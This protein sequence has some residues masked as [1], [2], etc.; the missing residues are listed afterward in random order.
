MTVMQIRRT[1]TPGNQPAPNS[2]AEGEL[3]VDM[4]EPGGP[5]LWV[6][7]PPAIDP[8]GLRVVVDPSIGYVPLDGSLPMTGPLSQTDG[9]E[10]WTLGLD[11]LAP[12][13]FTIGTGLGGLGERLRITP[14]PG[15]PLIVGDYGS[16]TIGGSRLFFNSVTVAGEGPEI[17]A[18]MNSMEIRG[19]TAEPDYI[20]RWIHAGIMTMELRSQGGTMLAITGSVDNDATIRLLTYGA[21]GNNWD[22]IAQSP[23][24]SLPSGFTIAD[25]TDRR[26]NIHAGV[27]PPVEILATGELILALDPTDPMGAV[28]KQYADA[29]TAGTGVYVPV[30][31]SVPMTGGLEVI[32]VAGGLQSGIIIDTRA[33]PGWSA[34]LALNSGGGHWFVSS[35][36]TNYVTPGAL[37]I[38]DIAS[39]NWSRFEIH[40]QTGAL[41]VLPVIIDGDGDLTVDRAFKFGNRPGVFPLQSMGPSI[42]S[43][44]IAMRFESA[45]QFVFYGSANVGNAIL[46]ILSRAPVGGSVG[47]VGV[48]G[49]LAAFSVQVLGDSQAPDADATISL[50][51][52]GNQS[53]WDLIAQSPTSS[54]LP[55][56]FTIADAVTG[57]RRFNIHAGATGAP[58]ELLAT[59]ELLLALDP[60]DPMGAVTKQYADALTSAGGLVNWSVTEAG[61]AP[62]AYTI[63]DTI[64]GVERLIIAPGTGRTTFRAADLMIGPF[65]F[66][67]QLGND[68][69]RINALNLQV[70]SGDLAVGGLPGV[71]G[72]GG[73][74]LIQG[75]PGGTGPYLDNAIVHMLISGQG[76]ALIAQGPTSVI[77]GAFTITDVGSGAGD[78]LVIQDGTGLGIEI[79][80]TGFVSL[81]ADPTLPMHAVTKQYVD[82]A[83]GSPLL[84]WSVTEAGSVAGAYTITDTVNGTER[85]V[86][87]P[88]AGLPM[89][90]DSTGSL[91]IGG[92][93]LHFVG[94]AAGTLDGPM[95]YGDQFSLMFIGSGDPQFKWEWRDGGYSAVVWQPGGSYSFGSVND[96]PVFFSI[97]TAGDE[98]ATLNLGS[99]SGPLA[100]RWDLIVQSSTSS[101][102]SA[103]TI[104]QAGTDG[105]RRLNIHPGAVAGVL[106]IELL[107]TNELLLAVDPTSPMGA[108]TKQYVDN[109]TAAASGGATISDLPPA[110]PTPGQ[111][112]FDSA[113]LKLLLFYDDGTSSQWIAV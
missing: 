91:T 30:D 55:S 109:S 9:T 112:W 107:A 32:P 70:L 22:L 45:N 57:T 31:G 8:T 1:P 64:S 111:L 11:G 104:S 10:T 101:A 33:D 93:T 98:D 60:T 6:G 67:D 49:S 44:D 81:L 46:S 27:A 99:G 69:V 43:N 47:H 94:T 15:F 56:G 53:E 23:T 97:G 36:G 16:L 12:R 90:I 92:P 106:P 52:F 61:S 48:S 41:P 76:W 19:K 102:P 63:T 51:A 2:L 110:T 42:W 35:Q 89:V 79:D 18:D 13:S 80:A 59:G 113:N 28:T 20:W 4:A 62:G 108:A 3:A 84:N 87:E 78:R 72:N 24:S 37:Q 65:V 73:K 50:N 68:I 74:L 88:G 58:V 71:S 5:R 66:E 103:F 40:P 39:G 95:L 54:N 34:A 82:A 105:I 17:Y 100:Q 38:M 25:G 75:Q 14:S 86:I 83:S 85:L 29:I 21:T 26:F 77:P 96:G 7:V